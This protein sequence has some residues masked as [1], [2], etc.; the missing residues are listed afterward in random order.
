MNARNFLF[1]FFFPI[2]SF[3]ANVPS[4]AC[5]KHSTKCFFS[6][7][8]PCLCLFLKV[9]DKMFSFSLRHAFILLALKQNNLSFHSLL[10]GTLFFAF[11]SDA[12]LVGLPGF[13]F[14]VAIVFFFLFVIL[15]TQAIARRVSY[16]VVKQ[17]SNGVHQ[18]SFLCHCFFRLILFSG[19]KCVGDTT[20]F[21]TISFR[22]EFFFSF[23]CF[24]NFPDGDFSFIKYLV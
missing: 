14:R 12:S 13:F 6:L 4:S 22:W 16:F 5:M 15:H 23:R 17:F 11:E 2:S 1:S 20:T 9:V 10:C 18:P 24:F 7:R 3:T 8:R 21:I 19:P